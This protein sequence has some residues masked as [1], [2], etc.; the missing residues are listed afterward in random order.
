METK[1]CGRCRIDKSLSSFVKDKNMKNGLSCYCKL[2]QKVKG[3]Q[4][5]SNPANTEKLKTKAHA[6]Y[7]KYKT[8]I[9]KYLKC[10]NSSPKGRYASYKSD[11]KKRHIAWEITYDQFTVFW[12][13]DCYYCGDKV[14]T[15]GLDRIDSKL[16]YAMGNIVSCCFF[17][18]SAK[19]VCS[20]EEFFNRIAKVYER[21]VVGVQHGPS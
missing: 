21:H 6:H 9:T 2:C 16:G 18:N 1:R 13:S 7:Q 20:Q 14:A 11:A 5:R 12:Q 8:T 3:L 17:C 15:I 19:N 4:Y 10:Y